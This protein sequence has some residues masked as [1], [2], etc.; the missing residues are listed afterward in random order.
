MGWLHSRALGEAIFTEADDKAIRALNSDCAEETGRGEPRVR[1]GDELI[2]PPAA[3]RSETVPLVGRDPG[4]TNELPDLGRVLSRMS[5][6]SHDDPR[7]RL[8]AV[9][10]SGRQRCRGLLIGHALERA[11]HPLATIV[12][13]SEHLS[14]RPGRGQARKVAPVRVPGERRWWGPWTGLAIQVVVDKFE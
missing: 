6:Q 9:A 2:D 7:M 4:G 12:N 11:A 8:A 1:V 10:V 3:V 13:V 14:A 5:H